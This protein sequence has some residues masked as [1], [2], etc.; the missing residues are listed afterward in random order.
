MIE[1]IVVDI[2]EAYV[3]I[4]SRDWSSKINNYFDIDWSYFWL[5]YKGQ[6]NKIKI[7]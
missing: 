6:S 3:V 2:P 5:P 7:E 1:I 4:L